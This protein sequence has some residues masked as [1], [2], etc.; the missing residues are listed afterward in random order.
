MG[1]ILVSEV[2]G[3]DV[4]ATN[5][6]EHPDRVAVREHRHLTTGHLFDYEFPAH[7]VSVFRVRLA[8]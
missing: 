8:S 1:E 6:F 3:P 2:N 7:S 4:D 5:S